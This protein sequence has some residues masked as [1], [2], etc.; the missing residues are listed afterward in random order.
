MN[1][2]SINESIKLSYHS[3][4]EKT[5]KSKWKIEMKFGSGAEKENLDRPR[6]SIYQSFLR[7]SILRPSTPQLV[8]LRVKPAQRPWPARRRSN[9]RAEQS[10]A[11]QSKAKQNEADITNYNK[12]RTPLDFLI[13]TNK[14]TNK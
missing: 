8:H 1:I 10:R 9:F 4:Y 13:W 2:Q 6:T 12:M 11:M 7:T 5:L 14:Q 3:I